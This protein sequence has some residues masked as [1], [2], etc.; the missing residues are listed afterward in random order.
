MAIETRPPRARLVHR[1]PQ[2]IA[3]PTLVGEPNRL[4]VEGRE[5]A[6]LGGR[7]PRGEDVAGDVEA[8]GSPDDGVNARALA[9]RHPRGRSVGVGEDLVDRRHE[10]AVGRNL[11]VEAVEELVGDAAG[12]MD[13]VDRRRVVTG[14]SGLRVSAMGGAWS[15]ATPALI[16]NWRLIGCPIG[17]VLQAEPNGPNCWTVTV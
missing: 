9:E 2:A 17:A 14:E 16:V 15:T 7:A 10:A 6:D 4:E 11:G 8:L 13:H 1:G 3:R 5:G 12:V